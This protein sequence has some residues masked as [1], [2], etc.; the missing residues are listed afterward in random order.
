MQKIK[1]LI[2]L[3]LILIMINYMLPNVR[4]INNIEIKEI[5]QPIYI[6]ENISSRGL[7][8]ERIELVEEYIF[9]ETYSDELVEFVKS[10]EGFHKEA[11]LFPGETYYT[12]GYGTHNNSIKAGQT[13]TEAEAERLLKAELDGSASYVKK[14]CNYLKLNQSQF[15]AL[16]SFTYN[17]GP[18]MLNQLTANGTRNLEEIK[19]HITSYTNHGLKGLVIRRN[20]ELEMLNKEV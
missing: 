10:K 4:T 12:I 6:E 14:K 19:E 17:G 15:D 7:E 11:Y 13:I 18:G 2:L 9:P 1:R 20:Q 5:D 8:E 16:V 3:N